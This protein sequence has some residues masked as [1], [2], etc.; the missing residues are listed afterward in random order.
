MQREEGNS[1]QPFEESLT[2]R[3]NEEEEESE[4][5]EFN[6][7]EIDQLPLMMGEC[8]NLHISKEEEE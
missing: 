8:F 2:K 1:V 7:E 6:E 4:H 5:I 3:S